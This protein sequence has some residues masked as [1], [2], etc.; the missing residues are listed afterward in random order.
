MDYGGRFVPE[1]LMPVLMEMEASYL[2]AKKDPS[3]LD[4]FGTLMRDYVGRPTPLTFAARLTGHLGGAKIYLKRE[5]LAHTGAHK[6]NNAI[7]QALLAR[8]MKRTRIIAETGAG[9]HG[10]AT[11]TAAALFGMECEGYQALKATSF[12]LELAQREEM[13]DP[14]LGGLDVTVEHRAVRLDAGGVD[15]PRGRE[16]ACAVRLVVADFIADP[17][18]EDL[19]ATSRTRIEASFSETRD[20]LVDRDP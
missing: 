12:V 10:V 1:T 14:F 6:I 13:V 2:E 15:R 17:F 5:D 18:G 8:R 3:F 11:A 9:Q 7:G 20:E 16:P 4:E 19:G